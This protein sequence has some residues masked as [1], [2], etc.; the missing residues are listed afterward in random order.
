MNASKRCIAV[1]VMTAAGTILPIASPVSVAAPNRAGDL[2]P[3][4]GGDGKVTTNFRSGEE[5]RNVAIDADG[6]IVVAGCTGGHGSPI[7]LARY[8]PNGTLDTSFGGGGKV[9]TDLAHKGGDCALDVAIQDDG[10]IVAAGHSGFGGPH[11][12]FAVVRYRPDGTL[13]KT[14]GGDGWVSTDFTPDSDFAAAV[15]IQAD[16]KI[17]AAG[18]SGV[19]GANTMFALARYNPDGTRDTTFGEHGQ[20]TTDFT[21]GD[22]GANAV[23]LQSDGKIVVA[24]G[25]GTDS[26]FGGTGFALARYEADGTL[27]T[28]F[29]EDGL[30]TTAITVGKGDAV[31][32]VEIL[33]NGKILAA[34]VDGRGG[35]GH[36]GSDLSTSFALVRYN[37]DGAIDAGFGGSGEGLVITML[38]PKDDAASD[39]A[40]Q[41]D[42][43]IV[44]AGVAGRG[45]RGGGDTWF[46]LVRYDADGMLDSTFGGD[47]MIKTNFTP[48]TDFASGIAIRADGKIVAAGIADYLGT[49]DRFALARYVSDAAS[50]PG[51]DLT[52]VRFPPETTTQR[53]EGATDTPRQ[54]GQ[55][56]PPTG[57]AS[58]GNGRIVFQRV[59][60]APDGSAVKIAMFTVKPPDGTGIRQL[61]HPPRGVE[62]G[63]ADWSPDGRWITYMRT[64]LAEPRRPR[65]FVMRRS[66]ADR[67]D[68]TKGHCRPSSCQGEND[69]AWSAHGKRIAFVRS[70]GDTHSIFVMSAAG[71]QRRQVTTPPSAR[72][73]DSAPAWSPDGKRIVFVRLDQKREAAALFIVRLDSANVRRITPW[74]LDDLNHPDWSSDGRWIVFQKP[75]R[76]GETHLY[77]I[78][79]NG[80]GLR[81]VTHTPHFA[82]SWA[83]FSPDGRM[84]TAVRVPGEESE[85]DVY[86]MKLDGTGVQLVTGSLSRM[87]AEGLPDWGPLRSTRP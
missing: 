15:A 45:R 60:W 67:T 35:C 30:V 47:G 21:G 42:G 37:A 72:F 73:I 8:N 86:V 46:A 68:L 82:W 6:E 22:D 76:S 10:K 19:F 77:L 14:F 49:H 58:P 63:R 5:L 83:G 64:G 27:D 84:I 3:T 33:S 7:A 53:L 85:N 75:S 61:T 23:G 36:C 41:A 31:A 18:Q 56:L 81:K 71:R 70:A 16:G 25:A 65:I 48:N 9:T 43:R 4:F 2:D 32:D 66:G 79:P 57:R 29:G 87:Q 13:D 78:H 55:S 39:L 26:D 69:P 80:A 54:A 28:S 44:V 34:G 20:V 62:T 11:A 17:I 52:Q 24:G 59:F 12:K 50:Q 1:V 51:S 74:R 38:S 40:V